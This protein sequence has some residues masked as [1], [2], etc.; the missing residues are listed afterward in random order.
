MIALDFQVFGNL[1]SSWDSSP[2]AQAWPSQSG[3][4]TSLQFHRLGFGSLIILSYVLKDERQTV[5]LYKFSYDYP[6]SSYYVQKR[7]FH[8]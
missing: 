6:V 2:I 7:L 3:V 8:Q 5:K 4:F 1:L